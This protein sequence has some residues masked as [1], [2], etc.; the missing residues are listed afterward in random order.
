MLKKRGTFDL[1]N[2]T[3]MISILE[4][5]Y[6]DTQI[7]QMM[8]MMLAMGGNDFLP[9]FQHITHLKVLQQFL[10]SPVYKEQL[11][12]KAGSDLIAIDRKMFTEFMKDLYC[13][14]ALHSEE[15]TFEEVRQL[16]IKPP[17]LKNQTS[18]DAIT[19]SFSDGQANLRHPRQ[20]L[21]P[22]SCMENLCTLYDAMLE[23][24]SGLG[25]HDAALPDFSVTCLDSKKR[26]GSYNLGKEAHVTRLKDL[27]TI[28]ESELQL[29]KK[30][31]QARKRALQSTPKKQST[32]KRMHLSFTP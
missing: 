29:Q 32:S 4:K 22:K 3:R 1:Y 25:R 23:Y 2:I 8:A 31:A 28:N 16:T 5:A 21:P 30:Y 13:P 19:F 24:F 14:P 11:F 9:K 27:L 15:L 17:T 20:W 18:S 26:D 6:G 12:Q 7:C 10:A